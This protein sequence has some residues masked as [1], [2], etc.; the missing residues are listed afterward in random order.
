MVSPDLA[1]AQMGLAAMAKN[2]K[3]TGDA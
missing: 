3:P 1:G 2:N